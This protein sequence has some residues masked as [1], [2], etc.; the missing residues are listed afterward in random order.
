VI[1]LGVGRGG[2][3]SGGG[4]FVGQHPEFRPAQSLRANHATARP[5]PRHCLRFSV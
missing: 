4:S 2:G 5:A 1:S 3:G